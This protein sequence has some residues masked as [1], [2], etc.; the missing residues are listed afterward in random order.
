[1]QAQSVLVT[2]STSASAADGTRGPNDSGSPALTGVRHPLYRLHKS[3][4]VQ[5]KFTFS[6]EFDQTVTVL[7]D[8]F[9][10]L[11]AIGDLP[12]EG[13]TIAELKEAIR[14]AYAGTLRDP[15]VSVILK[16]FDRP[17]FLVG[18]QVARPGKYEL[19]SPTT[20]SEAVAI[21]GGFTD[22]SKHSHVVVF[23]KISDG[24]VETHPLNLKAMLA[25][26]NLEE[27]LELQPGDMLF[28]PQ[29][30]I[31]KIR[32]FLPV[33]SLSTFFTPVQF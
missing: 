33:A 2:A 23:R 13:L 11:Q 14:D 28:V 16:D 29:N 6:P 25:S 22:Q 30:R 15:E 8:G 7:P 27:D 24:I 9:I 31:S 10:D 18:G 19:R 5:V 3:D 17:S 32:K 26:H 20:A 12:A 1:M 4:V 21:A